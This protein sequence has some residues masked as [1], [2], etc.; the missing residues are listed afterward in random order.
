[1]WKNILCGLLFCLALSNSVYA[2]KYIN[3]F[4][5]A[6]KIAQK[7]DKL[8]LLIFS[9]KDCVHCDTVKNLIEDKS[10]KDFVICIVNV[11][12][13]L[14]LAKEYGVR[15]F[16]TSLILEQKVLRTL[17]QSRFIGYSNEYSTWLE[18]AKI[19]P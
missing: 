18:S 16:P 19:D 7:D 17:E 4:S 6:K 12:T 14:N 9:M 10:L 2:E 15:L 11:E 13:N 3:N 8:I 5:N 1:M